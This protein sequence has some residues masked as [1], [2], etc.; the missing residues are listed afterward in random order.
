MWG[1]GS[2]SPDILAGWSG[3]A[4]RHDSEPFS[5]G[6]VSVEVGVETSSAFSRIDIAVGP[7]CAWTGVTVWVSEN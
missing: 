3:A 6:C 4:T 2:W 1:E 7:Y 5:S